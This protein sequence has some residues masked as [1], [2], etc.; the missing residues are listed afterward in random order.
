MFSEQKSEIMN[1][2]SDQYDERIIHFLVLQIII[3]LGHIQRGNSDKWGL[4]LLRYVFIR[5]KYYLI[6]VDQINV[7]LVDFIVI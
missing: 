1:Y 3:S 7:D 5:C 4:Y 2:G 6:K